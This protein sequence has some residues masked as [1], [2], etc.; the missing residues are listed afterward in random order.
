MRLVTANDEIF[1][2]LVK[3]NDKII[4]NLL[5]QIKNVP[6]AFMVTDDSS[7]IFAQDSR[8]TPGWLFLSDEPSAQTKEE[9]IALITGMVKL[10]PLFQINGNETL[11]R[12]I[13]DKVSARL[14][15]PYKEVLPMSVYYCKEV[16][17][18]EHRGQMIRPK[19]M[20]RQRLKEL[21]SSMSKDNDGTLIGADDSEKYITSIVHSK[22]IYL[23]E[24]EKIVSIA[25]IASK[26]E[27][28]ARIN[29]VFTDVNMRRNGYTK[30]LVGEISKN[31]IS[32]G[33]TPII[34]ADSRALLKIEAFEAIGYKKSGVITQFSFVQSL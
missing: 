7:Y 25:K 1:D 4:Y 30:M 21:I 28:F 32:E 22:S 23:W 13:L 6:G 24:D 18:V 8:R 26:N 10:N 12:P 27:G 33:I 20:H 5:F 2:A 9:L 31:L 15:L 3:E 17:T 19:E 34:Y 16:S 29:T 14:G 11:L